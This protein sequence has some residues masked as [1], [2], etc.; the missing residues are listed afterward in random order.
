MRCVAEIPTT[1]PPKVGDVIHGTVIDV[2][3]IDA[4]LSLVTIRT[5]E[6]EIRNIKVRTDSLWKRGAVS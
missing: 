4:R 2:T 3:N 1:E 6:G 5:P